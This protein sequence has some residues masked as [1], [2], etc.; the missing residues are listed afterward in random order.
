MIEQDVEIKTEDGVM[1][2]FVTRPE[3]GGPFPPV[4]FYMDAPGIREELRDMARRIASVGYYVVL[5]NLYYRQ[6]APVDLPL[7]TDKDREEMF[8]LMRGIGN[9]MIVE[10]TQN[11][12]DFSTGEGD[13]KGGPIGV[14]GYC[15]SGPFV[16]AIAAAYPDQVAASAS[17]YGAGLVTDHS[18]SPHLSVG[19]IKGEMYFACAETDAW[20][21][22][23]TIEA[24][25]TT[26]KA[27]GTN[28]RIEWF[29]ETEHGFAFP[30][31]PVYH[32]AAAERHWERLFAMFDRTLRSPA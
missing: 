12:I 27:A 16:T 25:E 30:Q 2:A 31:R 18:D 6:G 3:E 8:G 5:P 28:Y 9:R 22:K 7:A 21:P 23:E 11:L 20:A 17:I 10:D 29:P 4:F 13:A 1:P 26:L 32:K 15:M 24:L 19:D 14:V